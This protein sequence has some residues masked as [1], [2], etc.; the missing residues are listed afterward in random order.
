MPEWMTGLDFTDPKIARGLVR[1]ELRPLKA[2]ENWTVYKDLL[3]LMQDLVERHMPPTG[4]FSTSLATKLQRR[5]ILEAKKHIK[6]FEP[7]DSRVLLYE[8]D[9]KPSDVHGF[10]YWHPSPVQVTDLKNDKDS[11]IGDFVELRCM[12]FSSNRRRLLVDDMFCHF[13]IGE[14]CLVR[15]LERDIAVRRPLEHF[16]KQFQTVI[17][18]A[19]MFNMAFSSRVH[20]KY[21]QVLIP[22]ENG[23]LLCKLNMFDIEGDN[24]RWHQWRAV[25]DQTHT[26]TDKFPLESL[27]TYEAKGRK[28]AVAIYAATYIPHHQMTTEQIWAK[29]QMDK[30]VAEERQ[31]FPA[32]MKLVY[33]LDGLDPLSARIP[34]LQNRIRTITDN[35]RWTIATS[36]ALLQNG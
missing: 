33:Q 36:A 32:Y 25:A 20:G 30:L 16:T 2:K 8:D 10:F 11:Y 9:P 21:P 17:P 26:K 24:A 35:S 6:E 28:G 22:Y 31:Y 1:E 3:D 7:F 19:V 12:R 29:I 15:M 18:T 34:I 5:L 23:V 13:T 4:K 27:F 14:H